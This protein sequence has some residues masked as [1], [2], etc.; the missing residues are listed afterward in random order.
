MRPFP[1]VPQTDSRGVVLRSRY[2][3]DIISQVGATV[4]LC[5]NRLAGDTRIV[6]PA[7][8]VQEEY[9][10]TKELMKCPI[11][12]GATGWVANSIWNNMNES[13]NDF[14]PG[15]DINGHFAILGN[16][17]KT[18]ED[19]VSAIISILKLINKR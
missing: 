18:E 1:Q 10:L 17:R 8:G 2:R 11:P 15:I 14:F 5:G 19:F 16:P 9:S 4:F 3:Y 12:V 7:E 13:L 6:E